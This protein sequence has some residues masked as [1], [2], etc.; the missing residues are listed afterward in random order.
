MIVHICS[1][2]VVRLTFV[3]CQIESKE[4]KTTGERETEYS[5]R[6]RGNDRLELYCIYQ[7]ERKQKN[8]KKA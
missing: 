4:T 6:G 7:N 8:D 2:S 1:G 3:S 5:E